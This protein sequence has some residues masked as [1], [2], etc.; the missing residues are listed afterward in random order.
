MTQSEKGPHPVP[1]DLWCIPSALVNTL[2]SKSEGKC[3]EDD[4][5]EEDP[6]DGDEELSA[7][8]KMFKGSTVGPEEIFYMNTLFDEIYSSWLPFKFP[9]NPSPLLSSLRYL[10][11]SRHAGMLMRTPRTEF[12]HNFV[13]REIVKLMYLPKEERETLENIRSAYILSWWMPSVLNEEGSGLG[14]ENLFREL[15]K[16]YLTNHSLST[17]ENEGGERMRLQYAMHINEGFHAI[18]GGKLPDTSPLANLETDLP[19]ITSTDC[20]PSDSRLIFQSRLLFIVERGI[21]SIANEPFDLSV[22]GFDG[23]CQKVDKSMAEF[24]L[25]NRV[26]S[27]NTAVDDPRQAPYHATVLIQQLFCRLSVMTSAFIVLREVSRR[28]SVGTSDG[29]VPPSDTELIVFYKK[30][31]HHIAMG[32]LNNLEG[33]VISA[34]GSSIPARILGSAPD[35]LL[36][37]IMFATALLIKYYHMCLEWKLYKGEHFRDT[38]RLLELLIRKLADTS[39]AEGDL[40]SRFCNLCKGFFKVWQEK[41]HAK[42]GIANSDPSGSPSTSTGQ[43]QAQATTANSESSSTPSANF[44]PTPTS[45]ALVEPPNGNFPSL[46]HSFLSNDKY[47]TLLSANWTA[48]NAELSWNEAL[49]EVLGAGFF[50]LNNFDVP[51]TF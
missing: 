26:F 41:A 11:A 25:W 49:G 48:N 46:D 37:M 10:L 36:I 21:A 14:N 22:G 13:F 20:R 45:S 9:R 6:T 4:G 15:V 5:G 28:F 31:V 47:S 19:P 33:I 17:V 3:N 29:S 40:A 32:M 2:L 8:L 18:L 27:R 12:I 50:D 24:D 34:A 35:E 44:L 16:G 42:L 38:S 7:T 1:L 23:L 39:L 30:S 43:A 51:G